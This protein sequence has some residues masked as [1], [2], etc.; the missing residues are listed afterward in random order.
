LR[1]RS[2]RSASL[3]FFSLLF[4][5]CDFFEWLFY[6]FEPSFFFLYI[7][8]SRVIF[9]FDGGEETTRTLEVRLWKK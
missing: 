6:F 5:V 8:L 2:S 7:F 4:D 3:F 9:S 1:R